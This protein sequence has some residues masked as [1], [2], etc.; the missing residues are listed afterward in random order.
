MD[1]LVIVPSQI[2]IR[3]GLLE[4]IDEGFDLL[5][6]GIRQFGEAVVRDH[7]GDLRFLGF[8]VLVVH[9]GVGESTELSGLEPGVS[10][11][12]KTGS[13][14]NRDGRPPSLG[15]DD[16]GEELNLSVRVLVGVLR[17][18]LEFL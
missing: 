11:G 3:P 15:F 17:V 12:N 1:R 2:Q 14:R 13:S 10:A 16:L 8:V 9:R 7:V 4:F 6:V 5:H 18:G